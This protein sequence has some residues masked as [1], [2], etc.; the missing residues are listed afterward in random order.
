M[1]GMSTSEMIPIGDGMVTLMGGI[2]I[3]ILKDK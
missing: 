2:T 1:R 3:S